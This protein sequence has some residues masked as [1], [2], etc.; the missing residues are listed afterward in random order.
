[1]TSPWRT[2]PLLSGRFH[3]QY[4]DDLQVVVHDGGPR[5]SAIGPELMW[6]R[7]HEVAMESRAGRRVYRGALLNRPHRLPNLKIGDTILVLPA[8]GS[9]HPIRTSERY[10]AERQ[11][12]DVVPC[13]KCGFSEL[14][15]APS[16]LIAKV[17]PTAPEG[18]VMERFT[19]FC[20]LCGGVQEVVAE[21]G[22]AQAE[23]DL[24]RTG[25]PKR[26]WKLFS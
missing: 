12:Y 23:P 24:D 16:A 10:L 3:P 21:K 7:L 4:P 22:G 25:P 6:V 17:F 11:Q 1:M 18:C 2:D 14:F 19:S 15:D 8:K 20:P 26:W 9:E 13:Q 5:L